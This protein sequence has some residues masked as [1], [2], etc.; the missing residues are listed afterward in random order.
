MNEKTGNVEKLD[1]IMKDSF[2]DHPEMYRLFVVQR[3]RNWVELIEPMT[4]RDESVLIIVGAAHLVG[5]DSVPA[6]LRAK[7]YHVEQR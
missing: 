3:N 2:K 6:L 7:G 4:K 5:R 1:S